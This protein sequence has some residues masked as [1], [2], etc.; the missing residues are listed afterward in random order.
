MRIGVIGL[1]FMGTT[2]LKAWRQVPNA[3]LAA[4][5]SDEPEKLTGDLSSIQGNLGNDTDQVFDF[6]NIGRYTEVEQILADPNVE[7]VDICLPTNLHSS[8]AIQALRAGKHVLVE[9]PMALDGGA[10]QE[11]LDTAKAAG[12]LLMVGQVLRFFPAYRAMADEI[13]AGNVGQVRSALFRR[14]CAAP[15]WNKWLGDPKISG[16]GVF[17]LLI[18]DIDFAIH[19][20]GMP[21]T[22]SATGHEDLAGGID[23]MNATLLYRG[24]ADVLIT[25]GWHHKK[26]YP[27]SMEY[28]VVAD[29]GTFEF[30]S[31]RGG[32]V[33][34]YTADGES[35]ELAVPDEDAFAS[36]L[37]YFAE[38]VDAGRKPEF[39]P[40]EESAASVRLARFLLKARE[41]GG[42]RLGAAAV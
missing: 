37:R 3:Q 14:R 7:A 5:C 4:V 16:G 21:E 17:D 36:E 2:H 22:V 29:G 25:G 23:T 19:L 11:M 31:M 26:A 13:R 38:C 1:G 9:K 10:A 32:V 27:F 18:H 8:V 39:C 12:K 28:T 6:S 34:L 24:G 40:P 41:V 15:F 30:N 33:T 42:E 20:F 35:R